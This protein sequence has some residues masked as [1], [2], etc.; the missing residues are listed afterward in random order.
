MDVETILKQVFEAAKQILQLC[1]NRSSF[2]YFCATKCNPHDLTFF[3]LQDT[4]KQLWPMNEPY[5]HK[6]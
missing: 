6:T 4:I 3:S 2:P 5:C 1:G